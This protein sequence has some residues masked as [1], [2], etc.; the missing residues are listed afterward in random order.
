MA[1]KYET[2][3]QN[4]IYR[5]K[6]SKDF[7]DVM[8]EFARIHRFDDAQV[9]KEN[10]DDWVEENTDSISRE[11]KHLKDM[12]YTGNVKVKMYKSARYY[13]KNK[14]T[15][16]NSKEKKRCKY[17]GLDPLFRMAMDDHIE[18]IAF[19][20]ELKPAMGYIDFMDSEKNKKI[21]NDEKRR[22]KSVGFDKEDIEGKLKK[23]YKNRYYLK[24]KQEKK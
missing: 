9:F 17:V 21:I 3:P 15:K 2:A 13:F 11:T 8:T 1:T 19:R 4:K 23:T 7:L 14:S 12:G 5:Y 20:R 16:E 10:W 24:Q 6:F 18:T 22:L